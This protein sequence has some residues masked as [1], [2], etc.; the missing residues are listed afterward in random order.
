MTL[1]QR[2]SVVSQAIIDLLEANKESLG[3]E[4]VFDGD[5][6][7]I[8]RTPAIAVVMDSKDRTLSGAPN[9]VD[10]TFSIYLM[11][12][13]GKIQDIQINQRAAVVLTEEI[14]LLL[15]ADNTLGGIL[16][17]SRVTAVQQGAVDR[18]NSKLRTSRMTWYG[19]SKTITSQET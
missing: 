11:V 13:H 4:D 18:G 2:L 6:S 3:I 9:R 8:P 17:D 7:L 19:M 16:I 15:H 14:E 12:Y 1:T 10:N 5:M